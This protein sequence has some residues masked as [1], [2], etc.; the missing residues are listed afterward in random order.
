MEKKEALLRPKE[1]DEITLPKNGQFPALRY[2]PE[3]TQRLLNEAYAGLPKKA[4]KRGTR[5]LRRQKRRWF[6][7]RKIKKISK[8]NYGIRTHERRMQK[9]SQVVK[10]VKHA[11]REAPAIREREAAYQK[12]VL[13][14]WTK[15]MFGT[16]ENGQQMN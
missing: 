14:Q 2:S 13:E 8:K 10:D 3:E 7:V 16:E 6:L 15:V 4:G 11:K 12:H 1:V 5:N 9:R